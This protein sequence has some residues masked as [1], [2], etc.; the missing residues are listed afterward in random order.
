MAELDQVDNTFLTAVQT[1]SDLV[2]ATL[3][4][5]PSNS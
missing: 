2:N 4:Q 5:V 1:L 3:K